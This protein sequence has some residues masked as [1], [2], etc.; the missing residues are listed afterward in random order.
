MDIESDIYFSSESADEAFVRTEKTEQE[1]AEILDRNYCLE[2]RNA[3]SEK[4][5]N[6]LVVDDQVAAPIQMARSKQYSSA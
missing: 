4:I 3:V 1:A 5:T 2:I 6:R